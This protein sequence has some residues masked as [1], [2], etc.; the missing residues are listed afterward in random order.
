M[1]IKQRK[2]DNMKF[3]HNKSME[4]EIIGMSWP[5]L[6]LIWNG[7]WIELDQ[8]SKENKTNQQTKREQKQY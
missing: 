2:D 5:Y 3:V 1:D 8:K 7:T 4:L 6:P